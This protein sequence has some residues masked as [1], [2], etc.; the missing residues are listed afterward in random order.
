L[1]PLRYS[2]PM[3]RS[4]RK[5]SQDEEIESALWKVNSWGRQ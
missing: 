4:E 3:L 5:R 2:P 1:D